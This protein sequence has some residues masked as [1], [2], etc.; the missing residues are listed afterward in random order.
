MHIQRL[1]LQPHSHII[2]QFH[3]CP[4]FCQL[5]EGFVVS[6]CVFVAEL[7][8]LYT[9]CVLAGQGLVPEP[10]NQ[11][12]EGHH[13][14]FRQTFLLHQWIAGHLQHPA[15]PWAGTTPIWSRP[16]KLPAGATTAPNTQRFPAEQPRWGL[17]H[18]PRHQQQHPAQLLARRDFRVVST[19]PGRNSAF[20]E[21]WSPTT[22]LPLLFHAAA[23]WRP[24]WTDLRVR[25]RFLS[26]WA[27]HAAGQEGGRSGRKEDGFLSDGVFFRDF[28]GHWK[29]IL[30]H[31]SRQA[32]KN[33]SKIG[34]FGCSTILFLQHC[35][36]HA[37]TKWF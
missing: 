4:N 35:G 20:A 36:P 22:A 9:G 11:A 16:T 33:R 2:C 19:V 14:G 27:V 8:T 23:R 13:E 5:D 18:L 7:L 6:L 29:S 12:E 25:L 26:L 1:C 17:V 30:W 21:A 28:R 15:P 31:L 10:P 32:R 3:I 24:P 37:D 34:C